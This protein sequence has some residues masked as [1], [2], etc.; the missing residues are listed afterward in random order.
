MDH[1]A[2][3]DSELLDSVAAPVFILD[4]KSSNEIIY[5]F[6]NKCAENLSDLPRE[7]VLGKSAL[8]L[9]PGRYGRL[10]YEFHRKAALAGRVSTYEITLRFKSEL[11]FFRTTLTPVLDEAGSVSMLTGTSVELT[12]ERQQQ[13]TQI[14]SEAETKAL[15]K[16]MQQFL[17]MAA[18]DLRTPMRHVQAIAEILREDFQDLGDGKLE[19][20][21]KLEK[22]GVTAM[23]LIAEV[24]SYARATTITER[25][26]SFELSELCSAIFAVLDPDERHDLSSCTG[27]IAGDDVALQIVLRNLLDNAVKHSGRDKVVVS[28]DFAVA[29]AGKLEFTVRDNGRGFDDPAIAFLDSGKFRRES[30]FGLLGVKQLLNSRGCTITAEAL[31]GKTGSLIKFAFPGIVTS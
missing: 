22:V 8:E 20:I 28:I 19:L 3:L 16:E 25:C 31:P 18:H 23:E 6:W 1:S 13:Q 7:A 4:V 9:Y 5:R 21:G 2:H 12:Q 24:L 11:R 29:E 26:T 17:S 27:C 10:A 15:A 14:Q 30:G